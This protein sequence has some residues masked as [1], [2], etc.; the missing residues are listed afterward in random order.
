MNHHSKSE[1]DVSRTSPPG[2]ESGFDLFETWKYYEQVAMHFNDLLMRLRSQSLAA[3]AAVSAVAG[4]VLV[5]GD[6]SGAGPRYGAL[7][8]VFG[9]LL[10]FWCAI[11]ILD[12]TYYNRLLLGAVRALAAIEEIS[13]TGGRVR[14]LDLSKNIEEA[15]TGGAVRTDGGN[16]GRWSFYVL[17]AVG[18]LV[19]FSLALAA[20]GEWLTV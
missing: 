15:V 17:V 13:K 10:V 20:S 9:V 18:L 12:F 7:A 2:A 19:G 3:V 1:S 5:K 11:W 6:A 16:V 14:Q 4:G 8:G